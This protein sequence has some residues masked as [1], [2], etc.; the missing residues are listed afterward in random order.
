MKKILGGSERAC[1]RCRGAMVFLKV[2]ELKIISQCVS[3]GNCVSGKSKDIVTIYSFD[4]EG[5][6]EYRNLE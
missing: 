4:E 2:K 5:N 1:D 6:Y 3:C